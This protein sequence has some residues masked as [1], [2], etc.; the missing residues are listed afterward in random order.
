[1]TASDC[2]LRRYRRVPL[3]SSCSSAAQPLCSLFLS[4]VHLRRSR[5]VSFSFL[6]FICGAAALFPFPFSCSS[7]AQPLCSLFLSPVHLRRSRFVPF[8]FSCSSAA[9]PLC[10]FSFLLFIC[11]AAALFPFPFSCSSAAQPLW[12][13][14]CQRRFSYVQKTPGRS[15]RSWRVACLFSWRKHYYC[16]ECEVFQ[17]MRSL[18][19]ARS[20][21]GADTPHS[22]AAMRRR[23]GRKKNK[24]AMRRRGGRKNEQ[25]ASSRWICPRPGPP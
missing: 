12:S 5:S 4:P 24:A 9:Q 2:P 10:S 14:A 7:A 11:G 8:P 1:M 15:P 23:G 13:A 21:S 6:L 22:K 17:Q 19:P 18:R 25:A 16:C 3:S 20:E